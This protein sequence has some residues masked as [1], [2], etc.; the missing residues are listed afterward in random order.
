MLSMVMKRGSNVVGS[1]ES[2][3]SASNVLKSNAPHVSR[4]TLSCS[5]RS[6]KR[7]LE[8]REMVGEGCPTCV[9]RGVPS[10]SVQLRSAQ[11]PITVINCPLC[12]VPYHDRCLA[13]SAGELPEGFSC[14]KCRMQD[15]DPFFPAVSI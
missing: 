2:S 14:P 3:P 5:G 9:C 10:Q 1:Y 11:E 8:R 7:R 15:L 6:K 12:S 4:N 13:V